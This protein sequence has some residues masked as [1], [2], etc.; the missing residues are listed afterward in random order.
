[1]IAAAAGAFS[2]S[3]TMTAESAGRGS[4]ANMTQAEVQAAA[5]VQAE[6]VKRLSSN[7]S[8]TVA[9][10][11]YAPIVWLLRFLQ[12]L[13]SSIIEQTRS[14]QSCESVGRAFDLE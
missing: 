2:T 1:M 11:E 13:C 5:E 4:P 10:V 9:G 12:A 3:A 8:D 7:D 6:L 14:Q